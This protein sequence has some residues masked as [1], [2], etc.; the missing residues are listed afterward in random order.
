MQS[1]D[2]QG[3]H[4]VNEKFTQTESSENGEEEEVQK[5]NF[6]IYIHIKSSA[7]A[8]APNGRE[9]THVGFE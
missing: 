5:R 4:E 9:G 7:S 1:D 8:H 3:G 6:M 2:G